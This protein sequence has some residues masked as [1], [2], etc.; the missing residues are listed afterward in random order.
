MP[1]FFIV[2]SILG[3]RNVTRNLPKAAF[4]NHIEIVHLVQQSNGSRQIRRALDT[5][6]GAALMTAQQALSRPINLTMHKIHQLDSPLVQSSHTVVAAY[7]RVKSKHSAKNYAEWMSNFLSIEDPVVV[8]T[9]PDNVAKVK[10]MRQHAWN[11]TVIVEIGVD[12]LP[13]SQ[14]GHQFWEN[15][16]QLDYE[17]EIHQ[18]YQLFWIW[19]SK[20]WWTVQ[21][22]H[23][24][25]FSSD[26]FVYSDIGCFRNDNY[27]H[28]LIVRHPEV[29]P[30][31]TILWMA[32]RPPNPP[33]VKLW[34][35]KNVRQHFFHSGS[36]GAGRGEDWVKFHAAFSSTLD[37][38]IAQGDFVGEDQLVLQATCL[39]HPQLCA[40]LPFNQVRDSA[41]FGVR[42][43]LHHGP[44][45]AKNTADKQYDLWR[46]DGWND[47]RR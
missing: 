32:H 26:F 47:T 14:L 44:N 43:A 2:L 13:M 42:Y 3:S 28:K 23:L 21:A 27:N 24:N 18:S 41:Y 39:L 22:F 11:R 8:F 45:S 46:P 15:Q 17:K 36:Q 31:G 34:N 5:W 35:T 7:F 9:E 19:L 30:K 40:Y 10:E 25:Y 20:S 1:F 33:P 12:D 29:V 6:N 4:R 37:A 38:F 16:L